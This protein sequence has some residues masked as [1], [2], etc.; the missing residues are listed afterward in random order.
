VLIVG[1]II[2]LLC[3]CNSLRENLDFD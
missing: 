2:G 3:G 1:G